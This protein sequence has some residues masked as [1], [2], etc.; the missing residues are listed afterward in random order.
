MAAYPA[1]VRRSPREA[2]FVDFFSFDQ[3]PDLQ[4]ILR[5]QAKELYGGLRSLDEGVYI[6]GL[7]LD[8]ARFDVNTMKLADP[9]PGKRLHC[10]FLR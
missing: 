7:F 2:I 6:H 1:F 4:W 9:H 8:A 3:A 5:F 10:N